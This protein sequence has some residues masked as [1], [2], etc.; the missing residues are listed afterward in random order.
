MEFTAPVVLYKNINKD[1]KIGYGCTF[2][3][4]KKMK[5]AIIQCG[6]ADGIPI[7]FSNN[8]YVFY[9]K[10][11]FPIIG[12]V[13]MDLVCIDITSYNEKNKIDKVVIWGGENKYSR[14]EYIAKNF[15]TI[16]YI[17]LTGITNRVERVYV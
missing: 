14:L 1:D 6:Y 11:K 17:Y 3:A 16:P 2:H 5:V 12:R 9:K 8:G 7:E 15:N 10:F 13:S 4:N